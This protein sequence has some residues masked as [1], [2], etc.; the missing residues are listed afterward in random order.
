MNCWLRIESQFCRRMQRRT[1]PSFS[2]SFSFALSHGF[3]SLVNAGQWLTMMGMFDNDSWKS[4]TTLS[5]RALHLLTPQPIMTI[6][7][8]HGREWS[9]GKALTFCSACQAGTMNI[10]QLVVTMM[11]HLAPPPGSPQWASL[12]CRSFSLVV[13][14]SG[15][16]IFPW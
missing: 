10:W 5:Q 12:V 6:V 7:F 11:G 2:F 8:G 4:K 9:G 15:V 1:A 16:K 14:E 13:G 3:G